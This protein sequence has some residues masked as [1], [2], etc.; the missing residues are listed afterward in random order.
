SMEL[1]MSCGG[2]MFFTS[3]RFTLM[4]QGSVTSSRM[5]RIRVLI[6]SR[7]VRVWSSSRSP[8]MFRRVVAVG[9]HGGH[10]LLHAVA[11]QLG[12]GNL[13]VHHRVNLHGDVILG[14]YRLGGIVQHLLLQIHPPGNPV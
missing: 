12:V 10:G 9:L 7:E 8:M 1:W 11:V 2:R 4:P 3:T 13:E 5:E 6:T 14:D